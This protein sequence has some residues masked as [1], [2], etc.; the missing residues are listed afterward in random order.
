MQVYLEPSYILWDRAEI[1]ILFPSV[2]ALLLSL[3]TATVFGSVVEKSPQRQHEESVRIKSKGGTT[4]G[5]AEGGGLGRP[6]G[7]HKARVGQG[8]QRC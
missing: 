2:Y 7:R 3:Q 5:P 4:R 6:P 1:Y 8:K